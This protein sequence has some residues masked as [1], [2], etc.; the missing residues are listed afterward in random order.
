MNLSVN[1][2]IGLGGFS[3]VYKGHLPD[4]TTVAFKIM[5]LDENR[6]R[7]SRAFMAEMQTLGKIRHRNLV[8]IF[9]SSCSSHMLA[10]VMNY[11]PN[12]NLEQHLHGANH[13]MSWE[14]RFNIILG[15]CNSLAYLH[16]DCPFPIVHS[17]IKP[18]N[19]LLDFDFEP[20]L[21]DFGTA[22]WVPS[23]PKSSKSL[24]LRSRPGKFFLEG[25]Q[26]GPKVTTQGDVYSYGIVVLE[27]L[28][29]KRP[30]EE[31]LVEYGSLVK[32]V[33]S[34]FPHQ[35]D[36]VLDPDLLATASEIG[37]QQIVC[38]L[39]IALSCTQEDPSHRPSMREVLSMLPA[40]LRGSASLS[41]L[42]NM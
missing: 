42:H 31:F 41:P 32:W 2:V 22:T 16:H 27:L 19:I 5:T 28:T 8:T 23:K 25:Q 20:Y 26:R 18:S 29:R 3:T 1:S 7:S 15:L 12:G 38:M 14:Q 34:R 40:Q 21:G 17:D 4:G 24:S 35:I 36:Q 30:T 33:V 37:Q 13:S 39:G 10:I 11:I 6:G 9:G